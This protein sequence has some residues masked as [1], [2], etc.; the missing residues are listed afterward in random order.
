[1][2]K[3]GLLVF[4]AL[5]SMFFFAPYLFKAKADHFTPLPTV[6]CYSESDL[7]KIRSPYLI[8]VE[9]IDKW[10]QALQRYFADNDIGY[11]LQ[12]RFYTYLYLAQRDAA[13]LSY[14][15]HMSFIGSLD[16]LTQRVVAAFF[17]DFD[18][19]PEDFYT[20]SYSEALA[21]RILPP[22]LERLE[23][24]KANLHKFEP[25]GN[26]PIPDPIQAVA[27]WIPWVEPLPQVPPPHCESEHVETE[28]VTPEQMELIQVWEGEKRVMRNWWSLANAYIQNAGIPLGKTLF[29]RSILLMGLYDSQISV[30]KAKYTYCVPRP[31]NPLIEKPSSPGYPSGHAAQAGTAA[32]IL[33][34]F[35]PNAMD[36]WNQ[37]AEEGSQSRIWARVHTEQDVRVGIEL[38]K[39]IGESTLRAI[40]GVFSGSA[41]PSR[42]RCPF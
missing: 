32:V 9:R 19:L 40:R 22:Y 15:V 3:R 23:R 37:H 5:F 25:C 31:S 2:M 33:S 41:E 35:F 24:E 13:F 7:S 39:R 10:E 4:L 14:N 17:P 6:F 28:P 26:A 1:M 29:A 21:N 20:D 8:T 27:Q 42:H 11:S 38:G 36:L 12:L 16:P 34:Y 18:A 30:L